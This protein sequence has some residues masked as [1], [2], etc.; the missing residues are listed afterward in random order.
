VNFD[1]F[2]G[3]IA[4]PTCPNSNQVRVARDSLGVKDTPVWMACDAPVVAL[5]NDREK[6]AGHYREVPSSA[7]EFQLNETGDA[8]SIYLY[9]LL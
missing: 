4:K 7:V 1:H 2:R 9:T 6:Y 5:V 3:I 8:L